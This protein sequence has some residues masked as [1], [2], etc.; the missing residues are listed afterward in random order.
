[1]LSF[2]RYSKTNINFLLHERSRTAAKKHRSK[3]LVQPIKESKIGEHIKTEAKKF[4]KTFMKKMNDIREFY[5][6]MSI[7]LLLVPGSLL[8]Y[9]AYKG[10]WYQYLTDK[11]RKF[12]KF[13][14]GLLMGTGLFTVKYIVYII[15]PI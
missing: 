14:Y 7:E 10:N 5:Y 9:F 6:R 13:S 15:N 1:M 4:D 2:L 3:V 12:L 8:I 11:K